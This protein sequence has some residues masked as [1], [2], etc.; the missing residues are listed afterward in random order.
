MAG[1]LVDEG[2]EWFAKAISQI[3]LLVSHGM[4]VSEIERDP[5]D[6]SI[7][8]KHRTAEVSPLPAD[9]AANLLTGW[10]L[11]K[12]DAMPINADKRQALIDTGLID[13]DKLEALENSNIQRE[14]KGIDEELERKET[15]EEPEVE[16]P[17]AEDTEEV[18]TVDEP[19]DVQDVEAVEEVPADEVV[20]ETKSQDEPETQ[21]SFSLEDVAAAVASAIKPMS[22]RLGVLEQEI[23]AL[24]QADDQKVEERVKSLPS[25]SAQAIIA[26]AIQSAV[27]SEETIVDGRT[28]LAKAAPKQAEDKPEERPGTFVIPFVR[29]WMNEE[30][31][32]SQ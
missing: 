11:L 2:K 7:I 15:E 25:A 1:G 30:K 29:D 3:P 24:K 23:K 22:D 31:Q 20:E 13:P 4:P 9:Y 32:A 18:E 28:S 19:G 5:N 14:Q 27:S 26:K 17:A 12:E 16:S 21:P 8:T 10:M 6:K